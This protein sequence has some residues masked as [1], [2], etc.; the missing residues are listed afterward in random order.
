MSNPVHTPLLSILFDT[1]QQTHALRGVLDFVHASS[2][3]HG[4]LA[5]VFRLGSSGVEDA[6]AT[7]FGM[8]LS[9]LEF[10]GEVVDGDGA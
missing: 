8:L 9:L 1:L 3:H 2:V 6:M 4:S 10:F 5:A 7:R